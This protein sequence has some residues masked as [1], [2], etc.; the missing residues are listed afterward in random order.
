MPQAHKSLHERINER[1]LYMSSQYCTGFQLMQ[2]RD[3]FVKSKKYDRNTQFCWCGRHYS[4]LPCSRCQSS[5]TATICQQTYLLTNTILPVPRSHIAPSLS[6]QRGQRRC[7]LSTSH[8]TSHRK[9][10]YGKFCTVNTC[11]NCNFK[12]RFNINEI[13]MFP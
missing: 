7:R 10:K 2:L 11:K 9:Q 5:H 6:W 1:L 3:N 4:H 12:L 8:Q 13:Q